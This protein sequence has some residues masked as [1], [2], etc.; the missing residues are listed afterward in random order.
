MVL[1]ENTDEDVDQFV[2]LFHLNPDTIV[3][4]SQHDPGY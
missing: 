4:V 1:P 2:K 3:R